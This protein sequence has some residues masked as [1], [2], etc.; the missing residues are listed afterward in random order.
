M[1]GRTLARPETNRHLDEIIE[2][3]ERERGYASRFLNSDACIRREYAGGVPLAVVRA[4]EEIPEDREIDLGGVALRLCLSESPHTDDALLAYV[5][6][7]GILFVGDAQL[8]EFPT[9]RMDY[10]RLDALR[11]KVLGFGAKTVVDGHWHPY[12]IEDY[13][14]EL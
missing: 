13:L 5:P 9:W 3:M 12:R 2:K 14:D 11:N 8:G 10:D 7:D 1:H 6:G 4:D